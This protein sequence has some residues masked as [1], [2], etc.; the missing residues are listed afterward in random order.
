M[1]VTTMIGRQRHN[2]SSQF[3]QTVPYAHF[4]CGAV[5]ARSLPESSWSDQRRRESTILPFPMT[6]GRDCYTKRLQMVN[7]FLVVHSIS[8]INHPYRIV[9]V[10]SIG[11]IPRGQNIEVT[12]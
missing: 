10:I 6:N 11:A 9:F 7:C 4:T 8:L 1:S 2:T 12:I 5:M 3:L